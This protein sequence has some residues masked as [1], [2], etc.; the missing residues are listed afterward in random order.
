MSIFYEYFWP[1]YLFIY[2]QI[3]FIKIDEKCK[4]YVE[5]NT[6]MGGTFGKCI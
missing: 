4:I 5:E 1:R 3:Y 6:A 2:L